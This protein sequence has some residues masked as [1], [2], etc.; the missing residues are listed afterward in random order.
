MVSVLQFLNFFLM[1]MPDIGKDVK[2]IRIACG[3]LQS[4]TPHTAPAST[5]D[6]LT[7]LPML[8]S[9]SYTENFSKA[10]FHWS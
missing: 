9:K 10:T 5:P 7:V 1:E 6:P 4:S 2:T 8:W 3:P